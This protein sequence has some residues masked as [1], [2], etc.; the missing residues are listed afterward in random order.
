MAVKFVA[1]EE[2]NVPRAELPVFVKKS[3]AVAK[4]LMA[5]SRY[6]A[7]V[8]GVVLFAKPEPEIERTKE[9]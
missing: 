3:P 2:Y 4:A 9:G 8:S 7:C 5:S 6:K 1:Y